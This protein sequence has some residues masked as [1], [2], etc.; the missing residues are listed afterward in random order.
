[1]EIEQSASITEKSDEKIAKENEERKEKKKERNR[2]YQRAWR[3]RKNDLKKKDSK[4]EKKEEKRKRHRENQRAYYQRTKGLKDNDKNV[5][6]LFQKKL[7]DLQM[8][9]KKLDSNE[10]QEN[11]VQCRASQNLENVQLEQN[12]FLT[13]QLRIYE[14]SHE[15][16]TPKVILHRTTDIPGDGNCLFHS[17][18]RVEIMDES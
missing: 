7:D 18:I 3:Q 11:V 8:K 12:Q 1:M 17:L 5:E 13:Q 9:K 16:I 10:N 2:E 4:E 15:C 6:E 14:E